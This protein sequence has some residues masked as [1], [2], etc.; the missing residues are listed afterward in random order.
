VVWR[1]CNSLLL[2]LSTLS[3]WF[4]RVEKPAGD[5]LVV[6]RRRPVPGGRL[7]RLAASHPEHRRNRLA[8]PSLCLPRRVA[9]RLEVLPLLAM[10]VGTVAV[11]WAAG[12]FWRVGV[13]NYTGASA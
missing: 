5:L 13:R 10:L 4:V 7:S 8:S 12:W 9:G 6:H 2:V 11:W 1:S 3:F